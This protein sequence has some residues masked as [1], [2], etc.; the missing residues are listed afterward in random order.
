[1]KTLYSIKLI[2]TNP[3]I[4][5][6]NGG[7]KTIER[8]LTLKQAKK[9]LLEIFNEKSEHY[10][11]TWTQAKK[12]SAKSFDDAYGSGST[13]VFNYDSRKYFIEKQ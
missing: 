4:G 9:K 11:M 5:Q 1:M 7:N 12:Q 10:A 8:D 6:R 3:Y 13:A 2:F